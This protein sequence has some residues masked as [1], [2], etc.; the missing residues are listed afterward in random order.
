MRGYTYSPLYVLETGWREEGEGKIASPV[1]E[2][3]KADCFCS[4]IERS[5][6][7]RIDPANR[8]ASTFC[9]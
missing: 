2:S 4:N 1:E 7:C 9:Q 3:G 6:F 8:S 5:D